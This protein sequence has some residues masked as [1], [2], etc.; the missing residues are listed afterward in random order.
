MSDDLPALQRHEGIRINWSVGDS[1][2][3]GPKK[4]TDAAIVI[5]FSTSRAQTDQALKVSS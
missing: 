2:S 5:K 1:S 4:D 3:L